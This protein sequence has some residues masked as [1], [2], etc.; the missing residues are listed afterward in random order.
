MAMIPLRYAFQPVANCRRMARPPSLDGGFDSW[1]RNYLLADWIADEASPP[2]ATVYTAWDD[3]CLYFAFQANLR[4]PPRPLPR[5]FWSGDCIEVFLDLRGSL[6]HNECTEHCHHFFLLPQGSGVRKAHA[7]RCEAGVERQVAIPQD[8]TVIVASEA[9]PQ[10]YRM[11]VAFPRA[12]I[13]TYDPASFP[14]IGF[15]YL[16]REA[17]G[18]TQFWS[19]GPE[20][21]TFRDPS[22]WGSLD[23]TA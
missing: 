15:N 3:A 4:R 20:L 8:D 9:F 22:T 7:G 23:L 1:S 12:A 21:Q 5:R 14:H 19:V 2:F 13:P 16:I 6:K 17:G 10:G 18:R 11:E